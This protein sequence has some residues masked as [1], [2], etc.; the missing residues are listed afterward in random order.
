MTLLYWVQG[1]ARGA[2]LR[3]DEP[4]ACQDE[5]FPLALRMKSQLAAQLALPPL[6]VDPCLANPSLGPGNS[7]RPEKASLAAAGGADLLY[8]LMSVQC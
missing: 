6:L 3:P 5:V 8:L 7:P 2:F 4:L 1:T